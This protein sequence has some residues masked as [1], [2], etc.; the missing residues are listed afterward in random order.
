MNIAYINLNANKIFIGLLIVLI[1]VGLPLLGSITSYLYAFGILIAVAV[2]IAILVKTQVGLYLIAAVVPVGRYTVPGLPFQMTLAD[3]LL[4]IM[5]FSW[6]IRKL[7]YEKR[8][9]L[10]NDSIFAFLALFVMFSGLSLYNSQNITRSTFELIQTIEYFLIIPYLF[11]DMIRNTRQVKKIFWTVVLMSAVF[12][13]IGLYEAIIKGVRATS[14]AGHPNAFGIYLAMVLP[15]A[16]TLFLDEKHP[17]KKIFLLGLLSLLGFTLMAT[18]SRA[19]WLAAFLALAIVGLKKGIKKS[20]VI[21]LVVIG[22]V[23]LL[24]SVFMADTVS[25][26]LGTITEVKTETTGGRIQQYENAFAMIK[27]HPL[28][29]VGLNEAI[30][31]NIT[32]EVEGGPQIRA[33]IHNFYLAVAAERGLFALCA[34]LIALG[35]FLIRMNKIADEK[36]KTIS[37]YAVILLASSVAFLVGNMF[38]NSVGRGNGNFFMILVGIGLALSSIKRSHAKE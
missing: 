1:A 4:I 16:Y 8:Y 23:G 6:I 10:V 9:K 19:G 21:G 15:I 22:I 27:A 38:H 7:V 32:T 25:S 35:M 30:R 36:L 5:L 33:E 18:I 31:Y 3:I 17:G 14:I 34:L 20:L 11:F 29:G 26:R 12:A 37:P 2:T 24:V 13:P 28:L